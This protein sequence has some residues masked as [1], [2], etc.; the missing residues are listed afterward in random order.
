MPESRYPL[1][2]ILG[3]EFTVNKGPSVSDWID[4]VVGEMTLAVEWEVL[5]EEGNHLV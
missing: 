4:G 5:I 3:A 1:D 2:I